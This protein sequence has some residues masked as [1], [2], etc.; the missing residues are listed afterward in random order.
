MGVLLGLAL[1][2]RWRELPLAAALALAPDLDH[3]GQ[4]IP[5][6]A[7]YL[8]ARGTLTN[9]FTCL[10][11]PAGVA[12]WMRWRD[13]WPQWQRFALAAPLI[14]ASHLLLDMLPLDPLGGVGSVTLFW[15]V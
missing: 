2:L 3:A 7:P 4:F 8:V 12:A 14:L 6:L 13:V 9:V 5:A 11:L 15:P 1:R 10:L